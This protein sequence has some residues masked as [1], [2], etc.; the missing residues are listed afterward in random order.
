LLLFLTIVAVAL[1]PASPAA[2][3][4]VG[5][6]PPGVRFYTPPR[7]LPAGRHGALI[8]ARRLTGSAV[9]AAASIN[10]LLLYRSIGVDGR[11]TAM[12]GTVAIPKGTPRRAGWPVISWG[13][14]TVGLADRC[15]PTR[16]DVLGGYERPLLSRWLRAGFAVVRTDYEGLGTPGVHPDL[17]GI[18]EA[19]A[20]LDMVRAAHAFAPAL[21]LR[22]VALAG[23]SVGG[24]AALWS[25]AKAPAYTPE[26]RIRATVAFAP[27]SHLGE[28]AAALHA[29]TTPSGDL[30]AVAAVIVRGAQ[31]AD[32]GLHVARLLSPRGRALAPAV[33]DDCLP[34]LAAGPFNGVAPADL[35]K[36]DANL[37]RL[38]AFL[39]ANDPERLSFH[40]RVRIEQGTADP[41]VFPALTDQLAHGF[42]SRGLPVAY[43]RY[44]GVDHFGLVHA[45][46][47]DVTAYLEHRLGRAD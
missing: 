5:H 13:H 34:Q 9:L 44:A 27:S 45:A 40:T 1:V 24:H 2:A 31:A 12:S 28:Q 41:I 20:M 35:F 30:G 22:A 33:L 23:H 3:P 16:S 6:G 25:A 19:H 42:A 10:E 18:S 46:A 8:R 29:L 32:A 14:A 47:D 39:S 36:P 15:A 11:P 7:S 43:K 37:S 38:V 21:N 26:L 4:T 17:V